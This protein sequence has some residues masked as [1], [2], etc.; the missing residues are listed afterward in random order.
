MQ[1]QL[2][3]VIVSRIR[4]L[5]PRIKE[6]HLQSVD[7]RKLPRY[8]PGAHVEL[9]TLSP[10][11]GPIVRHYSL[12]GSEGL[13]DDPVN[14]YRIAVQREDRLRGSAHIHDTFDIGTKLR[15][16]RPKNNFQLGLRDKQTLLIAGGIGI[17]PIYSMMR[18]LVRRGRTFDMVYS[19]RSIELLAYA[20]EVSSLAGQA[21]T[22]HKSGADGASHLDLVAL[23]ERQSDDTTVYVCGPSSMIDAVHATAKGLGWDPARVRSESFGAGPSPDDQAFDVELRRTGTR[24]R[25]GRDTSVLDALTLAGLDLF[26]DC[27]RGECGLCAVP[28][29]DA[30][31]G[32]DHRDKYLSD[33][34]HQA[35][36]TMCI[37]VSR[38]RGESLVLDI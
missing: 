20:Q 2:L 37:C 4:Q 30:K 1:S 36:S 34:E 7:G 21:V 24:V 32:I 38:A 6:Y 11:S 17:T 23:L 10:V 31:D 12:V 26:S 15:V 29:A 33:E 22:L 9:H 35:N 28:V 13:I 18:S 16:S 8:A 19:G 5:T 27:R 14:V 3:D 25:I